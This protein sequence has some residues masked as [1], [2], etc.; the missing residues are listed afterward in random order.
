MHSPAGRRCRVS[1]SLPRQLP[2]ASTDHNVNG[3]DRR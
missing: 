3:E 2:D 1:A